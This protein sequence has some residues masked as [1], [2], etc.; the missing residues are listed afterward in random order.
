MPAFGDILTDDDVAA[1]AN[2]VIARFGATAS[3][4]TADEV[5]LLRES[6]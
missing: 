5:G 4:I 6:Y 3:S 2:Y 1:V